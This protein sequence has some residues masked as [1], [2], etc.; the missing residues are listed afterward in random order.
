MTLSISGNTFGGARSCD[1]LRGIGNEIFHRSIFGAADADAA[2]PAVM[3]PRNRFRL[4]V[5][6]IDVVVLID[7]QAAWP[8][9]LFPF[10]EELA[11]LI[12]DL[13]AIVISIA[14]E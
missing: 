14:H 3:I 7:I 1:L 12:K 10:G 9:E 11:I 8:A 13:D 5:C 4:G 2:L 6:R